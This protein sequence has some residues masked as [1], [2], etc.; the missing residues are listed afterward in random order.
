MINTSRDYPVK[1][2]NCPSTHGGSGYAPGSFFR[3]DGKAV[4]GLCG[5]VEVDPQGLRPRWMTGEPEPVPAP[6]PWFWRLLGV[7]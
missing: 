4:C 5:L 6:I 7:R 1:P 2:W 3:E